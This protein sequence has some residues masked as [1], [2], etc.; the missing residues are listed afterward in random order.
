[1]LGRRDG[2]TLVELIVVMSIV[3][4]VITAASRMMASLI[5]QFK[6]QS[7]IAQSG[8][9]TSM[10]LELLRRDILTAGYGLPTEFEGAITY[11][12]ALAGTNPADFNDAPSGVPRAIVATNPTSFDTLNDS[13]YLVI[14]S[15]AV[16][17]IPTAGKWHYLLNDNTRSSYGADSPKNLADTDTVVVIHPKADAEDTRVLVMSGAYWQTTFDATGSFVPEE[18]YEKNIIYGVQPGATGEISA[19]F[20]RADYY[21]STE[22]VPGRCAGADLASPPTGVLVKRVFDHA[23]RGLGP[24]IPL[25][26]CVADMQV[27]LLDYDETDGDLT[28]TVYDGTDGLSAGDI[29]SGGVDDVRVYLLAHEGRL[30]PG[31]EHPAERN[32]IRVGEYGSGR[33]FDLTSLQAALPT[34]KHYRWRVYTLTEKPLNLR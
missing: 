21:I 28:I 30:D 15:T 17:E 32:V 31:Y 19:P 8:I 2:L 3:M 1:M 6:Q 18:W 34:W 16:A 20:N 29:S 11:P 7:S 33:D 26:E 13:D 25:M 23:T 14:K 27:L 9:E 4:F 10:G 24:E 5:V 12:E 22:N